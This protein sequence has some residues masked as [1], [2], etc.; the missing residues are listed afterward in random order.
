M[1]LCYRGNT[2]CRQPSK[3]N[4]ID[5][6]VPAKYRGNLYLIDRFNN[7]SEA[8]PAIYQYRGITYLKT[9]I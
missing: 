5:T 9:A 1:Q 6:V 7:T 8:R 3:I 2:Y 4:L